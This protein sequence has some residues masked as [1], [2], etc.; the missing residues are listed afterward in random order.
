MLTFQLPCVRIP[1]HS[2]SGPISL[3]DS[4]FLPV[5]AR[6]VPLERKV[7]RKLSSLQL[8]RSVAAEHQ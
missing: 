5:K 3:G 1:E 8:Y 4:R 7:N 2:H 6:N